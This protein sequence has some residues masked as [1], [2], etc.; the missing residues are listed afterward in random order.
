MDTFNRAEKTAP[1]QRG[2]PVVFQLPTKIETVADAVRASSQVLAECA[3]GNLSP[4]EAS[5]I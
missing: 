1:I 2:R 3:A 4:S 5:E